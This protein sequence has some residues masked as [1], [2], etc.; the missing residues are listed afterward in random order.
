MRICLFSANMGHEE[1][2]AL[3]YEVFRLPLMSRLFKLSW[4]ELE[5][6][7]TDTDPFISLME[8]IEKSVIY[9]KVKL[10]FFSD[11]HFTWIGLCGLCCCRKLLRFGWAE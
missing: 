9:G 2:R 3:T 5:Q 1:I 8:T 4:E 6:I 7:A 11:W 10:N